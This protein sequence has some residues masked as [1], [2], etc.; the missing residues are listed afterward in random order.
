M[1]Y[2]HW[3]GFISQIVAESDSE[4]KE[5]GKQRVLTLWRAKLQQEPASLQPFQIDEIMRQVRRRLDQ[6]AHHARQPA[7]AQ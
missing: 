7:M 5:A 3:E 6:A 1:N 2:T 4:P